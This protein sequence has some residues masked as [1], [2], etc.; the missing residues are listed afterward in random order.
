[1][2]D[3]LPQ[4]LMDVLRDRY[5]AGVATAEAHF[6]DNS[7]DE[8][9]VTGALGQALAMREPLIFSDQSGDFSVQ[10]SYRKVRGRGLNAPERLYGSDGIFQIAVTTD[11]GVV[12]RLKGLPFQSKINWRGRSSSVASQSADIEASTGEG[13]V[14]DYTT[15]GYRA[16]PT[17][18]AVKARG[19]RREVERLNGTKPLGQLLGV[20]FLECR[21]GTIG[22]FFDPEA[23]RY[24]QGDNML[25]P[26]HAIT[27]HVVTRPRVGF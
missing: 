15:T 10:I 7:A 8:D 5:I 1:M 16:C 2:R 25:E 11:E 22:L 23:E 14:V 13:I 17:G 4:Q 6:A 18:L 3:L 12:V 27:T 20:D 19:N 24:F 26:R 21:I 9:S